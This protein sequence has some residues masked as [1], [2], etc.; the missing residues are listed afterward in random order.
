MVTASTRTFFW[1]WCRW[2][3]WSQIHSRL[4]NIVLAGNASPMSLA[5]AGFTKAMAMT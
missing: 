2:M 4:I 3:I 5:F 1:R